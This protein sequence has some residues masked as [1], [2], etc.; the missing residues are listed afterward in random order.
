LKYHSFDLYEPTYR[1]VCMARYN[2]SLLDSACIDDLVGLNG[3]LD[4]WP[5]M[6]DISG[7]PVYGL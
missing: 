5:H 6:K 4:L 2:F 3:N 1:V 7:G